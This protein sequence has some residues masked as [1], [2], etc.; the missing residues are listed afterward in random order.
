VVDAQESITNISSTVYGKKQGILKRN[1]ATEKETSTPY[2]YDQ[3]GKRTYKEVTWGDIGVSGQDIT[4][5]LNMSDA[6]GN[7][8]A[9]YSGH[10]EPGNIP[11]LQWSEHHQYGSSRLGLI[12]LGMVIPSQS[13]VL[14]KK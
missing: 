2:G 5:L 3:S 1:T 6:H 11:T 12:N 14:K 10:E 8:M 7:T 4:D 9:T 13:I